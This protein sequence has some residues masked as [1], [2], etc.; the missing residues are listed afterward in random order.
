MFWITFGVAMIRTVIYSIWASA[1]I[2]PW[3]NVKVTT[4]D[5]AAEELRE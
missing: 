1:E 4:P 2:Q 3:N 5:E